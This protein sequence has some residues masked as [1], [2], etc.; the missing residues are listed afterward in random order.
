MDHQDQRKLLGLAKSLHTRVSFGTSRQSVSVSNVSVGDV[1]MVYWKPTK[2]SFKA[3]IEKKHNDGRVDV[4]YPASG[5]EEKKISCTRI[6]TIIATGVAIRAAAAAAM[7]PTTKAKPKA[8]KSK[9]KQAKKRKHGGSAA[10]LASPAAADDDQAKGAHT[11]RQTTAKKKQKKKKAK[12]RKQATGGSKVRKTTAYH[13]FVRAN[14]DA[15]LPLTTIGALWQALKH[16]AAA[17]PTGLAAAQMR[18]LV[19]A[20]R[21]DTE[22]AVAAAAAAGTMSVA[23]ASTT[24]TTAGTASGSGSA[25]K[26]RKTATG[27]GAL[28]TKTTAYQLFVRAKL[29][30]ISGKGIKQ[31]MVIIGALWQALKID[32][33]AQPMGAAAVELRDLVAAALADTE[34]AAAAATTATATSSVASASSF[35]ATADV[36]IGEKIAVYWPDS[37][38]WFHGEIANVSNGTGGDGT[39]APPKATH[40]VKY[41]DGDARWHPLSAFK[42]RR[43]EELMIPPPPPPRPPAAA[44]RE[45]EEGEEEDEDED[46]EQLIFAAREETVTEP[47]A[48]SAMHPP[49]GEARPNVGLNSVPA[50]FSRLPL[51][52][53]L[54]KER[55]KRRDTARTASVAEENALEEASAGEWRQCAD[56]TSGKMYYF[57]SKTKETVWHPPCAFVDV[58]GT[59]AAEAAH[60]A[61]RYAALARVTHSAAMPAC[62]AAAVKIAGGGSPAP[63]ALALRLIPLPFAR[64]IIPNAKSLFGELTQS[65]CVPM[66]LPQTNDAVRKQANSALNANAKLESFIVQ[67]LETVDFKNLD[68]KTGSGYASLAEMTSRNV[69]PTFGGGAGRGAS[70]GGRGAG[71]GGGFR[72]VTLDVSLKAR[73][74]QQMRQVCEGLGMIER[75][76]LQGTL[77]EA[78]RMRQRGELIDSLLQGWVSPNISKTSRLH[79]MTL[80]EYDIARDHPRALLQTLGIPRVAEVR[81]VDGPTTTVLRKLIVKLK[82]HPAKVEDIATMLRQRGLKTEFVIQRNK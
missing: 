32:A 20:A 43:E 73:F 56:A 7:P 44:S 14:K 40:F 23:S 41:E 8:K 61:R 26:V 36:G 25:A 45:E 29:P 69:A 3:M 30:A 13:L 51:A 78:Q 49:P 52:I 35:A 37:S 77:T 63:S 81:Y 75:R 21:A 48:S 54:C 53:G 17:Q 11:A 62:S 72:L 4:Y 33:A 27:G 66:C 39:G 34:R 74:D 71:G 82:C 58:K 60:A 42:W 15:K 28:K 2:E 80:F 18:G 68:W 47:T 57:H 19:A 76:L 5:D 1:V 31:P 65:I 24:T 10:S 22:R 12:V 67:S 59:A 79:T 9:A 64:T 50:A 46:E 16:D 6:T 38:E 55:V 70:R